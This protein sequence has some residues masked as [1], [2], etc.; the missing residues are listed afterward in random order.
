MPSAGP[1]SEIFDTNIPCKQKFNTNYYTLVVATSRFKWSHET[2]F[3][4]AVPTLE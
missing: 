3:V 2:L 4:L 1:A